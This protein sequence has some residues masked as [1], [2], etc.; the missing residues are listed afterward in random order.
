MLTDEKTIGKQI[1]SPETGTQSQD[2]QNKQI[3][4]KPSF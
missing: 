1:N 2:N 4:H 3:K